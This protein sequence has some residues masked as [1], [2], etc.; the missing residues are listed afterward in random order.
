MWTRYLPQSDVV[1]HVLRDGALGEV[2]LVSADFG[3]VA[4][5][6]PHYRL[7]DPARGGGALLDA[8]IYPLSFASSILGRPSTVACV[9]AVAATGVDERAAV[10]LTHSNGAIAQ[11]A[12][13]I[14]SATPTRALIVGSAG[15]IEIASQFIGPSGVTL[16]L[17]PVAVEQPVTWSDDSLATMYDGLSYQATAL[18]SY[19]D[20]GHCESP[21]H[22]WDETISVLATIDEARRQVFTAGIRSGA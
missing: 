22:A 13:S 4:P 10:Q 1:R 15:R 12:T 16:A 2:H 19:V 14:V 18:A 21:L 11:V 7:W 8:G 17:G 3:F 5:R 20:A 9:G 6:H